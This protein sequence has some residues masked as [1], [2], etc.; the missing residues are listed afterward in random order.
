[1]KKTI[2]ILLWVA[3][4]V[5]AIVFIAIVYVTSFLPSIVL[6]DLKVKLTQERVER[7][8]Y[9]ANHVTVCVDC[10]SSRDWNKFSG[11]IKVGTEGI[12]GER[13]DQ[14]AGF[15]G[16]FVAPNIT[17]F[18]LKD[19]TDA[20]L[21]RAITSGVSKEGKPLFPVM[22][23]MLY[24]KMDDEDIYS[25]IAYVRTLPS[26]ESHTDKSKAGFPMN[27]ILHLI[28]QPAKPE[29]RPDIS[30]SINYGKYMVNA[31]A[32][33]ECHTPFEKGQLIENMAFA[34]GRRFPMSFGTLT[35]ANLTPDKETGI[36]NWTKKMFLDRFKTYVQDKHAVAN[37][38]LAEFNSIMPWTMY[39]EMNDEDLGAIYTY[40]HSLAPIKNS[41]VRVRV[42][43]KE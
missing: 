16:V 26:V 35:S 6:K 25:I 10:H 2:R 28:P 3:G 12:G 32:C 13:F 19:W 7:G 22:P 11:P 23:Y 9:L 27:V 31:S 33:I 41:V 14:K 15:P 1:M 30:D 34:G 29:K 20:E 24:G 39:A 8:K 37:V 38:G 21:Y 36:G 42:K 18:H 43:M 17:P 4:V 5:I 40:L